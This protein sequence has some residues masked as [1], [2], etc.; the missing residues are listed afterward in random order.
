MDSWGL[1]LGA[2]GSR[3]TVEPAP[4]LRL[5]LKAAE[6][7]QRKLKNKQILSLNDSVR[8]ANGNNNKFLVGTPSSTMILNVP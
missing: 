3:V 8:S 2:R 6:E 5:I 4:R 1:G 7:A